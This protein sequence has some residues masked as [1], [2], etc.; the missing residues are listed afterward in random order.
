[1]VCRG[2]PEGQ[3]KELGFLPRNCGESKDPVD[4]GF[5]IGVGSN[6]RL[7][8]YLTPPPLRVGDPI[9]LTAVPSEAGLPVTGCTV[10]VD[11][12]SPSG[13][14]WSGIVLFDDGAHEDGDPAD[15]EYAKV[16][17]KHCRGGKLH[18]LGSEHPA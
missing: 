10:T 18:L 15:G 8:A 13:A 6:F 16:F 9:R 12:T 17:S 3:E 2:W 4:Y 5:V 1:M 11:V 14:A 7:D